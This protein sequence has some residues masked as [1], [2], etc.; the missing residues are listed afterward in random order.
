MSFGNIST[1]K[2]RKKSTFMASLPRPDTQKE[3][4]SQERDESVTKASQE[5]DESVTKAS[6]ERDE[7]VTKAL[8]KKT[9]NHES[10]TKA[11]RERRPERDW[12]RDESV[13]KASRE[14]HQIEV[15]NLSLQEEN[16]LNYLFEICSNIGQR[17][18]PKIMNR[19]ITTNILK[20]SAGGLRSLVWRLSKKNVLKISNSKNGPSGWRIYELPED[21]YKHYSTQRNI[22]RASRERH[23]SV[24]RA[25]PNASL[26][27]SLNS[28]SSSSSFIY[29]E[30]TTELENQNDEWSKI[31]TP[32]ILKKYH[33][34]KGIITQV[35]SRNLLSP[36]ELQESLNAFAF[37]IEENK[38][39]QVKKIRNATSY[40]MKIMNSKSPYLP[41]GNYKSDEE[42]AMDEILQRTEE[43]AKKI[44]EREKRLLEANYTIWTDETSRE[45]IEKAVPADMF[46]Y[47]GEMH[48]TQVK[49]YFV[50]AI[51]PEEKTK[52][53]S[54]DSGDSIH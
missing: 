13:T 33:F 2:T 45:E 53:S 41:P 46:Q 42:K 52:L 48:S 3:A 21:T 36:G 5:R 26:R 34:G 6:Q 44:K 37:D 8:P 24:T 35:M 18:T 14:R 49:D 22:E 29:K 16:F 30:T 47:M 51:W 15:T 31:Q 28:S 17:E 38:V 40:F 11:S 23:E 1:P 32:E 19:E 50:K 54:I 20:T 25:S 9:E 39:I 27:A 7:S 12:V 43:K 4:T 10:V